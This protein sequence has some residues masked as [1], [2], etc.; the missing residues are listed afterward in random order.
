MDEASNVGVGA[1]LARD[2]EVGGA[3]VRDDL[4]FLGRCPDGDVDVVL[5]VREV[6]DRNLTQGE[7]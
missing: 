2:P 4:E 7:R 1:F 3:G 6:G 5:G